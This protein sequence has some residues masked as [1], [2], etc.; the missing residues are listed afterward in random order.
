MKKTLLLALVSIWVSMSAFATTTVAWF[1]PNSSNIGYDSARI[2]YKIT[3][4]TFISNHKEKL[5]VK[6]NN[7]SVWVAADSLM[8][9]T[10]GINRSLGAH[11]LLSS[12]NYMYAVTISDT[13]STRDTVICPLYTL[14]TKPYPVFATV[15]AQEIPKIG[16]SELPISA[17]LTGTSDSF[18]IYANYGDLYENS[19]DTIYANGTTTGTLHLITPNAQ[20]EIS[21]CIWVHSDLLGDRL[22][23]CDSF[24][25]PAFT[26][27]TIT[28]VTKTSGMDTI[29]VTATISTGTFPGTLKFILKDSIG[30]TLQ[31]SAIVSVNASGLYPYV[32][33]NLIGNK[34]YRFEIAFKDSIGVDTSRG[35]IRTSPYVFGSISNTSATRGVDSIKVFSTIT[36]GTFSGTVKFVLKDSIGGVLQTSSVMTVDT[37]GSY[38]YIFRNLNQGTLYR[39]EIILKDSS[40]VDTARGMIRTLYRV[41][42]PAP[43]AYFKTSPAPVTYCG[44]I[45][46]AG[47]VI[48]GTG[49]AAII[50]AF[51]DSNAVNMSDTTRS[52]S[53]TGTVNQGVYSESAPRTGGRYCWRIITWSTDGVMAISPA[54]SAPTYNEGSDP[55]YLVTPIGFSTSPTP[56]LQISGDAF[57]TSTVLYFT[58]YNTTTGQTFFDTV[59]VGYGTTNGLSIPFNYPPGDY[60][61]GYNLRTANGLSIF[62]TL[63]RIRRT[64]VVTGIK[65]NLSET[66]SIF[67][68]PGN[69]LINIKGIEKGEITVTDIAGQVVLYFKSFSSQVDI[70]DKPA[71]IYYL[72]IE[73]D[74]SK[75]VKKIIKF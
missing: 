1:P 27:G 34:F 66:V 56:T 14:T 45:D 74:D 2:V 51:N 70:T 4:T 72:S 35:F 17:V 12:T 28:N 32:F 7:S 18:Y 47:Y 53:V 55:N 15:T 23:D 33:R 40:H 43:V 36:L 20:D 75:A 8:T 9:S 11:N 37:T 41:L 69:G 6:K 24:I 50:R 60:D 19:S 48:T 64:N 54:I 39:F 65:Q 67:P 29:A 59:D 38:V 63:P 3:A 26:R 31:T 57:C 58:Y 73:T 25:T 30:T 61:I 21:Y 42:L 44:H 5:L 10:I 49:R 46:L 16:I 71:G 68:S 62:I 13:S 52:F 22:M